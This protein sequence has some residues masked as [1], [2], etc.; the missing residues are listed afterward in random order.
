MATHDMNDT[1]WIEHKEKLQ[2][3][4]LS[5]ADVNFFGWSNLACYD[6]QLTTETGILLKTSRVYCLKRRDHNGS[7]Q[8]QHFLHGCA[9]KFTSNSYFL[10]S[11]PCKASNIIWY[12]F[13][14]YT[15]SRSVRR[16]QFYL[17]QNW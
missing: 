13:A 11:T 2:K 16:I 6:N 14:L 1:I 12:L 8:S 9:R 10:L 4:L 5:K 7:F 3:D 17:I 15:I